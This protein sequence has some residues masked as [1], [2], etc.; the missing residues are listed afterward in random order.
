MYIQLS[1]K[2]I[3]LPGR[4]VDDAEEALLFDAYPEYDLVFS[5]R[6]SNAHAFAANSRRV[7]LESLLDMCKC[8]SDFNRDSLKKYDNYVCDIG[9]NFY[10]HLLKEH[11]G[12]HSCTP[13]LDELMNMTTLG[14]L[15]E[16]LKL[17]KITLVVNSTL[18]GSRIF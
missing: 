9:G 15:V 6:S 14:I 2:K 13:V 16:L 10:T 4:M 17:T 5:N 1:D 12:V 11:K 7:E 18:L 3:V 8:N